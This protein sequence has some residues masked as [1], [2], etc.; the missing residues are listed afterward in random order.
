MTPDSLGILIGVISILLLGV[1]FVYADQFG[2]GN[3]DQ[4]SDSDH[5][6]TISKDKI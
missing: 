2:N 5:N 6:N 4:W 3:I 1:L